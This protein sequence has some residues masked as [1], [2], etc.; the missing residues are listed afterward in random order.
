MRIITVPDDGCPYWVLRGGGTWWR[1]R[2][3]QDKWLL[4]LVCFWWG[5]TE[6]CKAADFTED[7][8]G[9]KA[10]HSCLDR[11]VS[12]PRFL[13]APII[14]TLANSPALFFFRSC[15]CLFY[16]PSLL[17]LS[18]ISLASFCLVVLETAR[19]KL[20]SDKPWRSCGGRYCFHF[21][22]LFVPFNLF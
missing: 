4:W 19:I 2:L 5:S 12:D 3:L 7:N 17:F 10:G 13:P 9:G 22:S 16:N 21:I 15:L 6:K 14:P 8:G 18:N 1:K 11:W 20:V